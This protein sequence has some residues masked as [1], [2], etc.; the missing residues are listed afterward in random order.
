MND[1]NTL[2]GRLTKSLRSQVRIVLLA[3]FLVFLMLGSGGIWFFIYRTE[4]VSW[5]GRQREAA[6][7][8][9]HTIGQTL[10]RVK[11]AL[12]WLGNFG[13]LAS[14]ED[15]VVIRTFESQI[16]DLVEFVYMNRDGEII[17]AASLDNEVHL[18]DSN[19]LPV[20]VWFDP[21]KNGQTFVSDLQVNKRNEPFLILSAPV[22]RNGNILAVRLK[23]DILWGVVEQFRFGK[24]GRVYI[25]DSKGMVVAH[26][27]QK[28]VLD[29]T[30]LRN[31]VETAAIMSANLH[32]WS[33][34]YVNFQGIPVA[35]VSEYITGTDWILISEVPTREVYQNTVMAATLLL[36]GLLVLGLLLVPVFFVVF[37]RLLIKPLGVL[38][39]GS[40]MIGEGKLD[41]RI[42]T[43]GVVEFDE[44][45]DSF[46]KMASALNERDTA[47]KI[48]YN[49]LQREIV[50]R[51][52]AEDALRILNQQ[53]ESRAE[54]RTKALS[55]S[56]ERLMNEVEERKRLE[57][58]YQNLIERMPAVSYV[59][60]I[61]SLLV[62]DFV[63]PQIL[64]L[65]GWDA[66]A[67]MSDRDM[68]RNTIH[69]DDVEEVENGLLHAAKHVQPVR[70]EYRVIHRDG[71]ILWVE[72]HASPL[73]DSKGQVESYQGVILDITMRKNAESE[74]IYNAYHDTLTGL[75]NR[76]KLIE[77]LNQIFTQR[78]NCNHAICFGLLFMDLDRFKIINDSLGHRIGDLLLV[79]TARRLQAIAQPLH[80]LSRLGGDEFVILIEGEDARKE[81]IQLSDRL[82]VEFRVPFVLDERTVFTT[83]S[84]GVV[85]DNGEYVQPEDVLRDA[86]IAMYRAKARGR[87]CYEVFSKPLLDQMINRHQ[88]EAL[89]RNALDRNEFNLY[90]QPIVSL[91]ENRITGFEA[92]IRWIT[93]QHGMIQPAEFI[94]LAEE[95]GLIKQIDRWVMR[96]ACRQVVEWQKSCATTYPFSV[97]V[98]L[99][100]SLLQQGD[101]VE[102]IGEILADTGLAPSSL[103][104]ELTE[105]VFLETADSINE[106]LRQ[107]RDIGVQLQIDDFGTGYSSLSYLQ[108][109]PITTIKI[110]R[111]FIGRIDAQF[112]GTE[113]VQAVIVLAKELGLQT[114]AEGIETLSQLHW[115][116]EAGCEFGQGYLLYKPM[117]A[118]STENLLKNLE[119]QEHMSA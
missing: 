46:N 75:H 41:L 73:F 36:V 7:N 78:D 79:E 110:D 74:L 19:I 29:Q 94:S 111:S 62:F 82:M 43:I 42:P 112:S 59:S 49:A 31:R 48:Q 54:D 9:A 100:G 3:V 32:R 68:R 85:I 6:E 28:I 116:K 27:D 72:D 69:P 37:D 33:G 57:R 60:S 76:T 81:S 39:S 34:E 66:Q 93:P 118:H 90:Y 65:T 1:P 16:P 114:I 89:L 107:I 18:A 98:N 51:Q 86:D 12:F 50:D 44:L 108:R 30:S 109:F 10:D 103:K 117:D 115:L 92:L 80:T 83:V 26:S 40:E 88:I 105:S 84:M 22:I 87:A 91:K 5:Q 119:N 13:D 53:L 47:L 95:T 2:P 97:S 11:G 20:S 35:G 8:A 23:M 24:Q 113:I 14:L 104:I 63:S 101:V 99:S 56:N 17:S 96:E 25:I 52:K 55:E 45:G 15:P 77:R 67:W 21:A 58:L 102:M 61:H 4:Q 70:M 38:T 106:Q 64:D 71:T